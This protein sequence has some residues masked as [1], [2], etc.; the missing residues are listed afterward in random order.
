MSKYI[1]HVKDYEGYEYDVQL[2]KDDEGYIKNPALRR[3][4]TA[5]SVQ[6]ELKNIKEQLK[7]YPTPVSDS[8]DQFNHLLAEL[9]RLQKELPD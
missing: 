8:D 1:L 4:Y 3:G 5:F 6:R 2:E 7:N 9:S